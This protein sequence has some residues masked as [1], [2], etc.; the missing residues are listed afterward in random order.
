MRPRRRR[1]HDARRP[2]RAG[3]AAL[4]EVWNEWAEGNYLEP[5]LEY[6]Y[7]RLEVLK[8]ELTNRKA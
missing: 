1:R 8:D 4:G 5:D 3:A 2:T 6:G 7:Q